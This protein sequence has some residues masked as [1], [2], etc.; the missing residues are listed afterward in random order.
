MEQVQKEF[1][2]FLEPIKNHYFDFEGRVTRQAFWM[3]TLWYVIIYI[4][5]SIVSDELASLASLAILLP[6][7]GLGARRLHDIGLSGWWQLIGLISL[8]FGLI[9]LSA[10]SSTVLVI[11]MVLIQLI[12]WIALIVLLAKQGITGANEYGAD[13]RVAAGAPTPMPSAPVAPAPQV[14]AA[15]ATPAA[16]TDSEV[17]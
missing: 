9:A 16:S 8:P 11:V 12:V 5:L 10:P 3:F 7:V 4:G 1:Q 14:T 6:S 2:W 15:P 17:R 13:P